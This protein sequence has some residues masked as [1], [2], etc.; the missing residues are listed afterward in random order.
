MSLATSMSSVLLMVIIMRFISSFAST[1]FTRTSSLSARSFTVMPSA[2]V[3]VRVIGGGGAGADAVAG[4]DGRS[5]RVVTGR[6]PGR[7]C[8]PNGGRGWHRRPLSRHARPRRR[9]RRLRA[10]RLRGQRTRS[11][12]HAGRRRPRRRRIVWSRSARRTW[13]CGGCRDAQAAGAAG[14]ADG[15]RGRGRLH[16]SRLR[17]RWTLG[18]RQR[19]RGLRRSA[20]LFDAQAQR[21]RHES[22]GGACGVARA[23]AGAASAAASLRRRGRRGDRCRLDD[24]GGRRRLYARRL[25]FRRGG[26]IS[27]RGRFLD[28]GGPRRALPRA[29][30]CAGLIVLTRR[31]GPSTGAAGFA[32]SAFL[33]AA[34][35]SCAPPFG[36]AAVSANM[37]PPGSEM[38]RCRAT[39]STNDRATTSSIVLDAL[40]SS[41]P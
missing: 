7:C 40:F 28:R 26:T 37:S 25:D 30:G 1:S 36:G 32:G 22:R 31:G 9:A 39:R 15:G 20:R 2:S 18:G 11:A 8:W 23:P 12:Q 17:D 41:M 24:L 38:L 29:G 35:P 21:R 13:T 3:I 4:A 33:G 10:D 19:T 16:H 34:R 6:C 5:R 27:R 14:F